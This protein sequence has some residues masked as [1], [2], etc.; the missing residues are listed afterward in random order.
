MGEARSRSLPNGARV[1][2][3]GTLLGSALWI[4]LQLGLHAAIKPEQRL[5]VGESVQLAFLLG[6]AG[7]AVSALIDFAG[8]RAEAR[9]RATM[10][11]QQVLFTESG[12]RH[13]ARAVG[14]GAR[15]SWSRADLVVTDQFL[16]A[17]SYH[18]YLG[19]RVRLGPTVIRLRGSDAGPRDGERAKTWQSTADGV[20]IT[21]PGRGLAWSRSVT[22]GCSHPADL[23]LAM[24]M[25]P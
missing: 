23:Q 6:F 18:G 7:S 9:V 11:S 24:G 15:T 2:L 25:P 19:V 4:A 1:L 20:T 3:L 13:A 12:V 17:Y 5:P 21:L 22:I 10:R 16:V 14:L 8:G